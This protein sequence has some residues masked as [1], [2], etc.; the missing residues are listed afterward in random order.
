MS[1][2]ADLNVLA[3]SDS[4]ATG[5]LLL[6]VDRRKASM[7][8]SEL[9]LFV[10]SRC[11]ALVEAQV[12]KHTY[13]LE[14]SSFARFSEVYRGPAKSIP[15]CVKGGLSETRSSG[16]GRVVAEVRSV[17]FRPFCILRIFSHSS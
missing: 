17:F 8:A 4:Y 16:S 2:E 5:G 14:S 10:N 9:S 6:L 12:N 7:K 1:L 3:L 13:V 15:V 11:T